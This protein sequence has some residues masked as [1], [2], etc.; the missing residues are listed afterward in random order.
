MALCAI[1]TLEI[2]Y[3]SG[4]FKRSCVFGPTVV[5]IFD[6][7]VFK[8]LLFNRKATLHRMIDI[9]MY[10]DLRISWTSISVIKRV[11]VSQNASL[12]L[13]KMI[14]LSA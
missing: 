12:I 1:K 13:R 8:T 2:G 10:R 9:Q 4:N 5:F 7:V 3:L 14:D 6:R 11:N